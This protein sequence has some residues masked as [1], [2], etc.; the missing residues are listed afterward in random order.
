MSSFKKARLRRFEGRGNVR[1]NGHPGWQLVCCKCGGLSK[2]VN[3][4]MNKSSLSPAGLVKKFTQMRWEVSAKKDD[5][6]PECQRKAVASHTKLAKEALNDM[7]EPI[8]K[9]ES[10]NAVHF[11][12]L[13]AVA[14]NLDPDHAKQLIDTLRER[15]PPK[16]KREKPIKPTKP[17]D[18]PDYDKWLSE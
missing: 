12:E 5:V 2:I 10:G 16:P 11:N 17:P 7:F 1:L 4:N 8:V 15:I 14:A 6:C 13:K 3:A 18:D 9:D